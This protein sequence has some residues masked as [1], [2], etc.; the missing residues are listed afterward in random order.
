MSYSVSV[1]NQT[2]AAE[3]ESAVKKMEDEGVQSYILD[4]RNNPVSHFLSQ[5]IHMFVISVKKD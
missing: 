4:L 2:A 1:L 5:L 3:M